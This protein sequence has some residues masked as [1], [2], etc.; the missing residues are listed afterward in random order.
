MQNGQFNQQNQRNDAFF[1]PTVVNAHCNKGSERNT[2]AGKNGE[3]ATDKCSQAYEEIVSLFRILA[4]DIFSHL[5][6]TQKDLTFSN[7]K[8]EKNPGSKL[9]VFDIRHHHNFSSAEPIK[10]RFDFRS[11]VEAAK[12]LIGYALLLTQNFLT[13]SSDGQREFALQ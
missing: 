7:R 13:I 10:V 9:Y 6:I 1:K 3:N 2:D 12:R 8:P 5:Y 4:K 11:P